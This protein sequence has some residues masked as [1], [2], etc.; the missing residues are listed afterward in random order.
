[1]DYNTCTHRLRA[2]RVRMLPF[3]CPANSL[4]SC[5]YMTSVSCQDNLCS[6]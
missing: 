2:R 4:S 6:D 3:K 1:M 5:A